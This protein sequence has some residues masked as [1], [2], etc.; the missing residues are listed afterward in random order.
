MKKFSTFGAKLALLGGIALGAFTLT[1]LAG[2][3][4]AAPPNPPNGNVDAPLNAGYNAQP[5]NGG[6]ILYGKVDAATAMTYGLDV[7]NAPIKAT[8]GLIIETRTAVTGDPVSPETG[9]MWLRTDL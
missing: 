8:G 5:K 7:V 3:W 1:V 6:L 2:D 4:V 9:R